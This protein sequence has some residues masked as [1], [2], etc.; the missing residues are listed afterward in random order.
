V[1]Y[2]E[3]LVHPA[4]SLASKKKDILI[5]GGGDGLALREIKR[6]SDINSITLVD[7][8]PQMIEFAKTNKIISKLNQ[9][10]F[11]DVNILSFERY[12]KGVKSIYLSDDNNQT[13]WVAKVDVINIDADIF[14]NRL[15]KK[16]DVII[17]DFPDPST[18]ELNKLYSKQFY[19][20]LKYHL[21]DSGV[22]AIQST[23]PYHAKEAFL[24]IG[25]TI[26]SAGL[27]TI[28]YHHNIPSFG[29]WGWYLVSKTKLNLKNIEQFKDT[30]YL[31]KEL[32]LSSLV[33]G[34]GELD[35]SN[36]DINTI[37]NPKLYHIYKN[38]SWLNYF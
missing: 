35:T 21:D 37:M 36:K 10:S 23:S 25:R 31:T 29:Q 12:K 24:C 38:N 17:I 2:H 32:F 19:M 9:N 34:K 27:Y 26:Q 6:Y 1:R 4:M 14:L 33:F 16:Y 15:D 11:Q 3:L 5:L 8:D 7:L 22:V 20:K 18:I 30:K 13:Q 28:P